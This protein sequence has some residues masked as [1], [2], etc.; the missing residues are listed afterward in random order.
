MHFEGDQDEAL[1][2]HLITAELEAGFTFARLAASD[3][4]SGKSQEARAGQVKAQTAHDEA[5]HQIRLAEG[6]GA[7][8]ACVRER[9][10]D[11]EDCLAGLYPDPA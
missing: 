4:A 11:L 2:R 9:L 5:L 7:H 6:H 1:S 3:Y 10:R 8:L